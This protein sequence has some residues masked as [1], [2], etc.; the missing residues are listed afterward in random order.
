M[1][2]SP[3]P[4]PPL[5]AWIWRHRLAALALLAVLAACLGHESYGR[6]LV[7]AMYEGTSSG[8]LNAIF[9]RRAAYDLAHYQHQIEI[10]LYG[11]GAL[12]VLA[13]VFFSALGS[14]KRLRPRAYVVLLVL[15]SLANIAFVLPVCDF[16][17]FLIDDD[18]PKFH[19]SAVEH[20]E[21][22]L[23]YGSPFGYNHDFQGG[24]PA[25]Y[26]KSSFLALLP[27]LVVLGEP[28]GHQVMLIV[29]LALIPLS[30]YLLL[31]TALR[32]ESL[33]QVVA[34]LAAF[35]IRSLDYVAYGM[36]PALV[37][38]GLVFLSLF[39]LLRYAFG[40]YHRRWLGA[41]VLATTALLYTHLL[42]FALVWLV[43]AGLLAWAR[44][45][46]GV[47]VPPMRLLPLGAPAF[48][49]GLPFLVSLI[50]YS[51]FVTTQ[52]D[53][54]LQ[55][56]LGVQ[57]FRAVQY[58]LKLL[59]EA[60]G[61]RWLLLL[62]V[63][64]LVVAH[65]QTADARRRLKIRGLVL[66]SA[67]IL[68]APTLEGLPHLT[69]LARR[70]AVFVPFVFAINAAL[71]LAPSLPART[72]AA[73]VLLVFFVVLCQCPLQPRIP[74]TVATLGDIDPA[75]ARRI[76]P[77]DHVLV[78]NTAH[79]SPLITRDYKRFKPGTYGHWLPQL[80]RHLGVRFFAQVGEDPHPYDRRRDMY[81][82]NGTYAGKPLD[83]ETG[84]A[85]LEQLRHWG[86][87][88][89]CV[90]SPAAIDFFT[91]SEHFT[92]LADS[93]K[94]RCFQA[95]DEPLG[96]V[97]VSGGGTGR[98][99]EATPFGMTV[100]LENISGPRTVTVA[101]NWFQYWSAHDEAGTEIPLR[102]A[103]RMISFEVSRDGRVRLH[104]RRHT[105][106]YLVAGLALFLPFLGPRRRQ[107]RAHP[108]A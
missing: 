106:L 90:W 70:T 58:N 66:L 80:Q 32:D 41:A 39:F 85:L 24:V 14:G 8:F 78:E 94:Y 23:R 43:F 81:V 35:Q 37:A 105:L 54:P 102:E 103:C 21:A 91:R 53:Y 22:L 64:F 1:T 63:L 13:T 67:V 69:T 55:V 9:H 84:P 34:F 79:V 65:A 46:A 30:L 88:K 28:L 33:A 18:Y 2:E 48:L 25:F 6:A 26:M 95:A 93:A 17:A 62:S 99:L 104:Y 49:A 82:T 12:L 107:T 61:D 89:V 108:A 47:R 75:L 59:T 50:D 3:A 42:Y 16:G 98:I 10:M 57:V 45:A 40:G 83:E 97:R 86:V 29:F 52:S 92:F 11:Y 15:V 76:A 4:A 60:G 7:R 51:A 73:A 87:N 74:R 71:C 20:A 5:R 31:R 77:G 36:T 44:M 100:A 19:A 96:E 101:R 38:L 27:F 56:G 72:R 68:V